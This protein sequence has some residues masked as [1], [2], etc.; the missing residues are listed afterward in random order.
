MKQ[1]SGWC[2]NYL[3]ARRRVFSGLALAI[4][5]ARVA[6]ASSRN[7]DG[8]GLGAAPIYG[9]RR[10]LRD[11]RTLRAGWF[12]NWQPH[13]QP[14]GF[15]GL[16]GDGLRGSVRVAGAQFVPMIWGE[17]GVK[18]SPLLRTTPRAAPLMSF[19]E[20]DNALQSC[21]T[22]A[23]AV[24]LWP[25]LLWTGR[26]LGSP[27]PT[28]QGA[29]GPGSWLGQFMVLA[30]ARNYRVD[31]MCT[32]FYGTVLDTGPFRDFLCTVHAQYGRP[33]WVTEWALADW[34][35]PGRFSASDQ[36]EYFCAGLAMLNSLPFVE[37]HA[38][39]G[40]YNGMDG[41]SINS[42]LATGDSSLTKVGKKFRAAAVL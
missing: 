5:G 20:P 4:P 11:I 26:R 17:K 12:Y 29:L 16:A 32:H 38:W 23:E 2:S 1:C 18:S 37:R 42:G 25:S 8:L 3:L 36:A 14:P 19:N 34:R 9:Q 10:M 22:P 7:R 39:F 40:I 13:L 21:L 33:V 41:W 24:A 30:A 31:F 15:P 6:A 28:Q 35:A 27:A